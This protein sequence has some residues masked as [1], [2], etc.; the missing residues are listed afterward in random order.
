[1]ERTTELNRE[2]VDLINHHL[3]NR[4]RDTIVWYENFK[5]DTVVEYNDEGEAEW[6]ISYFF[7]DFPFDTMILMQRDNKFPKKMWKILRASLIN[8][9]KAIRIMS[10]PS[11]KV[12]VK[13]AEKYG[14]VWHQDEI[15]FY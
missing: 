13:M 11:N 1:M 6:M 2:M 3:P 5:H 8:R 9:E 7:L 15:W 10:D 14:G 12:L 4:S